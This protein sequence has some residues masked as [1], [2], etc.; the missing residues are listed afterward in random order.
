MKN[1][2]NS[3]CGGDCCCEKGERGD[4]GPR[5]YPG[6]RGEKGEKGDKGIQGCPVPK[7]DRGPRGEDG[8]CDCFSS[9]AFGSY[10]STVSGQ[11]ISNGAP[12]VF[13]KTISSQGIIKN[14]DNTFTL[15]PS[16]FWKITLSVSVSNT[17][18]VS[19]FYLY[20][21]DTQISNLPAVVNTNSP[22]NNFVISFIAPAPANSI[23]KITAV[24]NA[25]NTPL[26]VHA[27]NAFLTIESVA[28]YPSA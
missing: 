4:E 8:K 17:S 11:T 24:S 21:N 27:N 6:P 15:V 23:L 19:A 14:E 12:I 5:G 2:C 28:D 25:Q 1:F 13:D 3:P 22:D 7:G 18:V 9:T 26:A 20:L 10:V 16:K